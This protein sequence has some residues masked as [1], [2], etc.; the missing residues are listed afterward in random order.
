MRVLI[1]THVLVWLATDRR[2][3]K[4]HEREVLGDEASELFVSTIS[5]WE[6]RAKVRSERRRARRDLTLDPAGALAF[7]A[8]ADIAVEEM[9]TADLLAPPLA[10]DWPHGDPFDEMLLIHAERLGARLLTRDGKLS[11]HPLAVPA[12]AS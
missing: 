10:V 11:G 3:L 4:R 6:L 5:L 9:T 8:K 2:K 7:C 12:S 1:D